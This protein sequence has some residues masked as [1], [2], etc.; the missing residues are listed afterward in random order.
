MEMFVI[1]LVAIIAFAFVLMPLLRRDA[2]GGRHDA[3]EFGESEAEPPPVHEA[4]P[5][6]GAGVVPPLAVGPA[7]PVAPAAPTPG[8]ADRPD[9]PA[10]PP[11]SPAGGPDA[12]AEPT[13]R[14]G[15]AASAAAA[16][17]G[18]GD[19]ELERDVRRYRDAL[20]AGTICRKCGEANTPDSMY[21]AE[22]GA[23]LPLSREREFE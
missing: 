9:A 18:S 4:D 15:Q 14:D 5:V 3:D 22:C 16:S 6:T 11:P 12:P 19:D 8:P 7:S 21:C 2:G 13:V 10:V 20:R 17:P 1:A 23:R